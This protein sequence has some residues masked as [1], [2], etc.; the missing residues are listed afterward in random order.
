MLEN[1]I[2]FFLNVVKLFEIAMKMDE[3]I[4]EKAAKIIKSFKNLEIPIKIVLK[5]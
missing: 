3:N 4:V 1:F 2:K 5:Y